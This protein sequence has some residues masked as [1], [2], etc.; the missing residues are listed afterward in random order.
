MNQ[1]DFAEL[2]TRFQELGITD[3]QK[4]IVVL[5]NMLLSKYDI[6]LSFGPN[7][8]V[9]R[10][11]DLLGIQ[12]E[13]HFFDYIGSSLSSICELFENDFE[14]LFEKSDYTNMKVLEDLY[15]YS[16]QKYKLHFKHDFPQKGDGGAIVINHPYFAQFSQ[17]YKRRITR[18]QSLLH[19]GKRILFIRGDINPHRI[20]KSGEEVSNFERC[21]QIIR[22]KY[23]IS[24]CTFY[25][26]S[27]KHTE[28]FYDT[29]RRLYFIKASKYIERYETCHIDLFLELFQKFAYI[30]HEL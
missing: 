9:R 18:L 21:V 10:F 25:W 14:N 22:E 4:E 3:L 5:R 2:K 16:N 13:T 30:N 8:F 23:P 29:F 19:S 15:I 12:Q 24:Q 28:D 20:E 17:K 7:C 6:I 11:L 27:A 26:I 1:V